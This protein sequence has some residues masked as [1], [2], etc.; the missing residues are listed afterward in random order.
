MN[1]TAYQFQAVGPD[2]Y[3]EHHGILGMKWGVRRYQN[4]DGSLTPAGE[5]RY[6]GSGDSA[7]KQGLSEEE[8][9]A[10]SARRKQIAKGVAIGIGVTAAVVGAAYLGKYAGMKAADMKSID[11]SLAENFVKGV[12][13]EPS[14]PLLPP[15]STST[16]QP[17][18]PPVQEVKETAA[19]P[20]AEAESKTSADHSNA[21]ASKPASEM[22]NK[23][24]AEVVARLNLEKKYSDLTAKNT[25]S[26]KK[27]VANIL[28]AASGA[29]SAATP[30]LSI[31]SGGNQQ[32]GAAKAAGAL[33]TV[34]SIAGATAT[35]LDLMDKKGG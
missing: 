15:P 17:A 33:K 31:A 26:G 19:S 8:L 3:L 2:A 22:S 20:K 29:I 14:V 4:K 11:P 32:S 16:A 5:K 34:G 28:R 13:Q 1:E 30:V 25:T 27:K 21:H 24:L 12:S 7:S 18:T 35:I 6:S 9:A 23:E 10:R